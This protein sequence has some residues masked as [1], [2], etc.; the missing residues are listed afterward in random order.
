MKPQDLKN[1]LSSDKHA[2]ILRLL[3]SE[4]DLDYNSKEIQDLFDDLGVD[5]SDSK[6]I[7]QSLK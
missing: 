4:N 7:F 2:Q 6:K 1:L 5:P 3:R